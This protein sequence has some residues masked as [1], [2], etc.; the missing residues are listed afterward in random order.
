MTLSRHAQILL[1]PTPRLS[2]GPDRVLGERSVVDAVATNDQSKT[3]LFDDIASWMNACPPGWNSGTLY[4][5]VH[6]DIE[7]NTES[8]YEQLFGGIADNV[9]DLGVGLGYDRAVVVVVIPPRSPA[10]S[11]RNRFDR[12]FSGAQAAIADGRQSYLAAY[13]LNDAFD[14]SLLNG[15]DPS[16]DAFVSST[17]FG[18]DLSNWEYKDGA[19]AD[20]RA[21]NGSLWDGAGIHSGSEAFSAL[22][23]E[24]VYRLTPNV[25]PADVTGDLRVNADDLVV[26]LANFGASVTPHD[27]GDIDG[28]GLV[29]GADLVA[30]LSA[31]GSECGA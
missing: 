14:N 7:N 30:V 4:W 15:S 29:N 16:H 27:D 10:Q 26:I 13:N 11:D 31:F 3:V 8:Q 6:F 2:L 9:R 28:D 20:L 24:A 18:I 25:C 19:P 17:P 12:A 5:I 23:A 21:A 22:W 1:D